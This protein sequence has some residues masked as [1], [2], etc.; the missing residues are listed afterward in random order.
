M[1]PGSEK[2]EDVSALDEG[3]AAA[4]RDEL[5]TQRELGIG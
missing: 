3:R 4:R 1:K 5:V 2:A